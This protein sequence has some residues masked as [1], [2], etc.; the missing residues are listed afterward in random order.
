MNT[1]PPLT[2]APGEVPDQ[3]VV[4][5]WVNNQF[6]QIRRLESLLARI[7]DVQMPAGS[8]L[9]LDSAHMPASLVISRSIRIKVRPGL[10]AGELFPV[11]GKAL[12]MVVRT[13]QHTDMLLVTIRPNSGQST[14]GGDPV[15]KIMSEDE[16]EVAVREF[17]G[18]WGLIVETDG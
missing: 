7:S 4:R 17:L 5:D 8:S 9:W 16:A 18:D 14:I 12:E 3:S 6:A 15:N 11:F 13:W 10:A 2:L 1:L